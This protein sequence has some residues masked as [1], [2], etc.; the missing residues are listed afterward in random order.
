MR[1][2]LTMGGTRYCLSFDGTVAFKAGKSY[3]AKVAAAPGGC[4]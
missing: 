4:P 1:L 2:V 3:I